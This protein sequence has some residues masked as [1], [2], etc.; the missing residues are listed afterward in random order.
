[1]LRSKMMCAA[2]LGLLSVCVRTMGERVEAT[3][4]IEP[5]HPTVA[6]QVTA[7]I[8][9]TSDSLNPCDYAVRLFAAYGGLTHFEREDVGDI[10]TFRGELI[11]HL[12]APVDVVPCDVPC[13]PVQLAPNEVYAR[14]DLGRM[15]AGDYRLRIFLP[16][17]C[18][19]QTPC[20]GTPVLQCAFEL[21]L[22]TA[23]S[24]ERSS[25]VDPTRD[26]AIVWAQLRAAYNGRD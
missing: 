11:P 20:A 3:V 14:V 18:Q 26:L 22:E 5:T 17:L 12:V 6:D 24:V 16:A 21:P 23:F 19:M 15:D 2:V 8:D 9:L 10:I 13:I 4:R 7:R 1:M 25:S